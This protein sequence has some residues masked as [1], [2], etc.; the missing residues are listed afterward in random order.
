MRARRASYFTVDPSANARS[1][2]RTIARPRTVNGAFGEFD[3]RAVERRVTVADVHAQH[4][5]AAAD[6]EIAGALVE[7]RARSGRFRDRAQRAGRH[8]AAGGDRRD[9]G[10]EPLAVDVDDRGLR[11]GERQR[12]GQ[13]DAGR[14][15]D[16]R[17]REYVRGR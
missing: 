14:A 17:A 3:R 2:P 16:Q 1:V 7:G 4:V 9:V 12:R 15:D 5:G 6:Q 8:A 13:R 10:D 11:E